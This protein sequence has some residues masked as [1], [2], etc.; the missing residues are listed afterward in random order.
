[1]S[2]HALRLVGREDQRVYAE[3]IGDF[4]NREVLARGNEKE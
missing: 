2:V 3:K 1:M 4:R